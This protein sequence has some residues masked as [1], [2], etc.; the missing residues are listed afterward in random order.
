MESGFAL[1]GTFASGDAVG[2]WQT[3][4]QSV[5]FCVSVKSTTKINRE[6]VVH[7]YTGGICHLLYRVN[8]IG[9]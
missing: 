4:L 8:P 2:R 3:S 9:P 1:C 7:I 6:M 5:F